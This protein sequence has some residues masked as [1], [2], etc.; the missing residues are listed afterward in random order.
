MAER[1]GLHPLAWVAIGC[2]GLLVVGAV[3][4]SV[5]MFAVGRFAKNKIE[6]IADQIENRPVET[7]AKALAMVSPEIEF[8]AADEEGRKATFRNTQSGEVVSVD[9]ADIQQGRIVFS[10]DGEETTF[11]VDQQ[12]GGVR[13]TG[14]QGESVLGGGEVNAPSWVPIPPNV[15]TASAFSQTSQGRSSGTFG[16]EGGTPQ[17]LLE[18]YREALT[19]AGFQLS[20]SSFSAGGQSAQSLRGEDGQGRT[21][22]VTIT[23]EGGTGRGV[24]AYDGPSS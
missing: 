15:K 24:V 5:A 8:V 21:V 19:G 7:A 6:D 20:E 23:E 17:S 16:L 22:N 9:M 18:F 1:K 14:P 3:V 11:S 12:A 10:K 4:A 13:V 2:A